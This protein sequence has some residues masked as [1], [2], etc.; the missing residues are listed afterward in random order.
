M[1]VLDQMANEPQAVAPQQS[2]TPM[3]EEPNVTPEEQE[4]YDTV[5]SNAQTIIFGKE[6][7]TNIL[8]MVQSADTAAEGVAQATV[9]IGDQII[10][11]AE[12]NGI[13]VPEDVLSAAAEEVVA[14]IFELAEAA[15]VIEDTTDD[16]M[17]TAL[18]KSME[19]W[20]QL[21][22]E[23]FNEQEASQDLQGMDKAQVAQI[24]GQL[25]IGE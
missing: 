24:L 3:E 18:T 8:N 16:D 23:R 4:I 25:G 1:G 13:Q 20:A 19:M 7:S 12:E 5:V 6:S 14:M 10:S 11:K 2:M 17:F 22:P 15:K 21:H 9:T